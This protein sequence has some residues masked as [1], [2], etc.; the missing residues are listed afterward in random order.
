M[1]LDTV[2]FNAFHSIVGRSGI[3]DFFDLFFASYFPFIVVFIAIVLIL[4]EKGH[5][6]LYYFIFFALVSLL[7]RGFFSEVISFFYKKQR[8]FEYLGFSPLFS[9]SGS[10]FPSGHAAFLFGLAFCVWLI[11]KK[12]GYWF[13]GFALFN[14]VTRI[15]G[16]V[17]WPIDVLGG[18]LVAMVSFFVVKAVLSKY[19]PH[20]KLDDSDSEMYHKGVKES[21][22]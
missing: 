11:N 22:S 17:H 21:L 20:L 19:K 8:P 13:F 3:M 7:S 5:K 10:S 1:S 12:W 2:I 15:I 18:F 14:G 9:V 4:K 16:G 6:R